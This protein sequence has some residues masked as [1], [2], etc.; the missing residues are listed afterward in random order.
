MTKYEFLEELEKLLID[1]NIANYEEVLDKYRRRFSIAEEAKMSVEDAIESFGSPSEIVEAMCNKEDDVD[2]NNSIKF[3]NYNLRIEVS[4][5]D[6]FE[7]VK[8]EKGKI[9]FQIDDDIYDDLEIIKDG[10]SLT[11]KDKRSSFF[12]KGCSGKIVIEAGENVY[13]ESFKLKLINADMLIDSIVGNDVSIESVS[14][15][16][17][18]NQIKAQSVNISQVSGDSKINIINSTLLKLS[19]VSGDCIVDTLNTNKMFLTR[20]SGDLTIDDCYANIASIDTVTGDVNIYGN[21]NELKKS[22]VSGSI[23]IKKR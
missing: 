5:L 13:F 23:N 7:L 9:S 17:T 1:A 22:S 18:I 11:I 4:F 14:G 3:V 15:D 19:S 6:S 2:L 16:C 10:K 21:I 20:V 12:H 8:G